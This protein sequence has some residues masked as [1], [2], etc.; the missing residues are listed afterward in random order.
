MSTAAGGAGCTLTGRRRT[1]RVTGDGM[2]RTRSCR[3]PLRPFLMFSSDSVTTVSASCEDSGAAVPPAESNGAAIACVAK[4]THDSQAL[5]TCNDEP[6]QTVRTPHV[7]LQKLTRVDP[8]DLHLRSRGLPQL[9][10]AVVATPAQEGTVVLE[11]LEQCL[12]DVRQPNLRVG[13]LEARR[14]SLASV[15]G[16]RLASRGRTDACCRRR[17]RERI[18]NKSACC[19]P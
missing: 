4:M 7:C 1:A 15:S 16:R 10:Q 14:K 13:N 5:R 6:P 19:G 3:K 11:P 12:T 18:T 9:Q 2:Y 17:R 8:P